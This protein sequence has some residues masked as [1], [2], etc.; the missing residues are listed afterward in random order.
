M[1]E[2]KELIKI[3][4]IYGERFMHL[5]RT[6]FPTILETEVRLLEILTTSFSNNCQTLYEDITENY[7][8]EDFK[9][10]IYSKIDMEDEE[11]K[12][13]ES[14]TP[15]ELLDEAGYNLY[16]CKSEKEIQSFKKYYAKNEELC[17]FRGG[18]LNRCVVYFAVRKDVEDI[19]REDYKNPK[20]EDKYGTSVMGIQFSKEGLCTVSIKNR[21]NHTVN[22]PDATYGN[23]LDRIIP[24]LTQSFAE[25][26]RKKGLELNSSNVEKF[27]IPR[28]VVGSDGKYYKYNHEI[29]GIYYCPGNI[30]IDHGNVVKLEHSKV[31]IDYFVID[32]KNN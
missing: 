19:K 1:S 5:C 12:L 17:T 11:K 10:Y 7:L 30:V 23:D 28:Y 20:R 29:N 22:N 32:N 2:S 27:E 13:I 8:V 15:Y 24:G 14:K 25:E 26:L 21:Y 9:N 31:L 6:L 4:K 3:K 18:R 16:E